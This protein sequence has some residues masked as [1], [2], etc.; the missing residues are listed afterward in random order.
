VLSLHTHVLVNVLNL[1]VRSNPLPDAVNVQRPPADAS[2]EVSF[3]LANSL[4]TPSEKL[5]CVL[6]IL[7][8]VLLDLEAGRRLNLP[9]TVLEVFKGT[10]KRP[11]IGRYDRDAIS[12]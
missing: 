3:E 7:E 5:V 8:C 9:Q 1:K 10:G 12:A 11:G 2:K 4:S 6:D